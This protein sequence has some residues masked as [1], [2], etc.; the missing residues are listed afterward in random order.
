[1]FVRAVD[2]QIELRMLRV[3]QAQAYYHVLSNNRRYISQWE[4]WVAS[5]TLESTI[6]Y[7]RTMNDQYTRGYGFAAAIYYREGQLVPFQL[8]GNTSYRI[9][10]EN[11]SVEIGY[12]LSESYVGRGIVTRSAHAL[13]EQ[14]FV[15][16]DLNRV[17]I[18][19]ALGNLRSCAIAERLGFSRDGVIRADLLLRGEYYDR[20]Y[21]TLLTDDWPTPAAR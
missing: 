8:V 1:M 5:S 14:A 18:R 2:S 16:D 3:S 6:H 20:A 12:W 7:I 13:I 17:I 15:H 11:R 4:G 10:R 9:N 21:Y 19:S